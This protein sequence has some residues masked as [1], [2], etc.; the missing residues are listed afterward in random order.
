MCWVFDFREGV[1][2]VDGELFEFGA[3][4]EFLYLDDFDGNNLAGFFVVCFVD[5]AE[6]ACSYNCFK[7]VILDFLAHF[8]G[9]LCS[10]LI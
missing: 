2:F 10:L 8:L 6:L 4:F 3:W 1:N 7:N 9:G 5:F